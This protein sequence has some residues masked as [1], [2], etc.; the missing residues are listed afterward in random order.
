MQSPTR[1]DELA[2]NG[3]IPVRSRPFA[4]PCHL[5]GSER[6]LLLEC[7][8]SEQWSS[9]R[10]GTPGPEINRLVGLSSEDLAEYGPLEARFVGGKYVR[11][12]ECLFARQMKTRFA[13]SANSATSGLVMALG[14][15]D[16]NPGDEVLVPCMS[17][18]ST[19][20]S[21]LFFDAVPV[22][23]EV[24]P[25]TYCID[26]AD[27]EAKI[28]G[29]TKAILV[30]HLGGNA[31]DMDSIMALARRHS[32]KVIEDCAQAP[33]VSYR[34]RPVG[35]IGD[36]GVFSLTETKTITCGEGGLLVTNDPR[37]ARKARLIRNHGE[38]VAEASW[39]DD[40]LVNVVGMNFRLTELQAA[41]AVGQLRSLDER[42]ALRRDNCSYLL[43][44][45]KRFPQLVPPQ[46]E[47]GGDVVFYVLKW[48]YRPRASDP[49]RAT[50]VRAMRAEGIPLVEGYARLLH[51][52]P[53]FTRRIAFGAHGI[54]FVPPYHHRPLRYGPGACPRSEEI[55]GQFLWFAPVHPPNTRNDMDDVVKAFG[56]VLR[57]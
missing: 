46:A 6:E 44:Q 15:I 4:P 35:S 28:G 56:K 36:A 16:L 19:A 29:D 50:L 13:V 2:V 18:H 9:F 42:N 5:G 57:A 47:P 33:G 41:V 11:Q 34:G 20:T 22:F 55:N 21:V 39:T 7:L 53:L 26:P 51:E 30:V 43:E 25:D 31:A 24:K 48:R 8:E 40:E 45:T 49:D 54:P 23:V 14:A 10:A 3:G 12:L 37:I 32:L 38:G 52:L 17:F 27:A 1:D